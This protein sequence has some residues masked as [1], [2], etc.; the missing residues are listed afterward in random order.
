MEMEFFQREWEYFCL[1]LH[2]EFTLYIIHLHYTY[3]KER[4]IKQEA[5]ILGGDY[6]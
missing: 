6:I 3:D 4:K 5:K 2:E 1:L